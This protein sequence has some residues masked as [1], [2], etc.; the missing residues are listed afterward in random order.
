MKTSDENNLTALVTGGS[1]GIGKSISLMLAIHFAKKIFINY[2]QNDEEAEKT[3]LLIKESD[4]DAVLLRYNLAYPGEIDKM[5]EQI[6]KESN[7]LG[8]F[9]HCAGI[10][11]FKPVTS[12]T[13]GQWDLIMNVNARSFLQCVQK[14]LPV[15]K[16]GNI[17]AISSMGSRKYIP[18]Y[19]TLSE[20]KSALETLVRDL[21]VELAPKNIRVNG[22]TAGLVETESIYKFPGSGDMIT[23]VIKH[24]P[25]GRIGTPD[26]IANAVEFLIS[27][28]AGWIVGQNII[29]D[30]GF[31]L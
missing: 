27:L 11:S 13:P 15:M 14:C 3:R 2:V 9:I 26:D 28:K 31:S 24:T 30:G 5:F 17:I 1:R 25:A 6:Y 4:C 10:N 21:A 29:M 19:G 23:K 20:T 22:I 8:V 12:I 18:N 16:S 7:G